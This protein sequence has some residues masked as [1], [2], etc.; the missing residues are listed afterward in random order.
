MESNQ[1]MRVKPSQMELHVKWQ[2]TPVF[3]PGESQGR[4][5]LVG[6]H[7]WGRT[8]LDPTERLSSSSSSSAGCSV[9]SLTLCNPVDCILSGTSVQGDFPGKN[10]GV[11]CHV[12][13]QGIFPTQ[14]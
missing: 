12:L 3:L 13:F 2:P 1:F 7:L 14:G 5:S 9:M 11:G 4:W 8:E 6:C 10:T